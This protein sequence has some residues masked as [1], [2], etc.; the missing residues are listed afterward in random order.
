MA[1]LCQLADGHGL[2]L[3]KECTLHPLDVIGE[4]IFRARAISGCNLAPSPFGNS[5]L[6]EYRGSR[7]SFS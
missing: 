7:S 3:R 5:T 6:S 1:T 2:E 4:L